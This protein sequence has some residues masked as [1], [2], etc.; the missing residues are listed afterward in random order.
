MKINNLELEDDEFY[1]SQEGYIVFT[2]KYLLKRGHCCEN[3][4]KHCPYG[5]KKTKKTKPNFKAL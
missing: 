5:F 2:E 3:A 1:Y 4:C